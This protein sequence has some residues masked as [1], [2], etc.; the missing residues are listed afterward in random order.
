METNSV[1]QKLITQVQEIL[2]KVEERQQ[3]QAYDE[4]SEL[5]SSVLTPLMR[6]IEALSPEELAPYEAQLRELYERILDDMSLASKEHDKVR[7][8]LTGIR[9]KS[10]GVH[11][12]L[13]TSRRFY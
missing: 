7:T 10:A 8:E 5:L 13:N 11:A 3:A 4:A 12:Y 1:C 9:R 6:N 2:S